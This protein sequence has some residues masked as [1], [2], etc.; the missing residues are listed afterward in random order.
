MPSSILDAA[1]RRTPRITHKDR[2]FCNF[3]L[4]FVC[5]WYSNRTQ[6]HLIEVVRPRHAPVVENKRHAVMTQTT[7]EKPACDAKDFNSNA[8]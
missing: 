1:R 5:V 3:G 8:H 2:E 4:V 6:C 7:V